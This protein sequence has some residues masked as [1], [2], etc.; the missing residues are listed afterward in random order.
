MRLTT[1]KTLVQR[2][3]AVVTGGSAVEVRLGVGYQGDLQNPAPFSM[4]HPALV[5]LPIESDPDSLP[6][7]ASPGRDEAARV[8]AGRPAGRAGVPHGR[9]TAF[10]TATTSPKRWPGSHREPSQAA[11]CPAFAQRGTPAGG[12]ALSRATRT[13]STRGKGAGDL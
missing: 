3:V 4:R 10:L 2:G 13:A 6:P 8:R 9:G 12:K 1:P 5:R 11:A 7:L